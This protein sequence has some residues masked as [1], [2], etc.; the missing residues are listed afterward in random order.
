MQTLDLIGPAE[1][2]ASANELS[3]HEHFKTR[4]LSPNGLDVRSSCGVTLCVDGEWK[5]FE[6][7]CAIVPGGDGIYPVAE[8][9][10]L[11]RVLKQALQK[12]ELIMSVCTGAFLLGHAGFLE[13]QRAT[14]H[15][16]KQDDLAAQFSDADVQRNLLYVKDK[17]WT[18]AGVSTGM[19][20]ALSLVEQ[21]VNAKLAHDVAKFLVL[22]MR[23]AGFEDQISPP[24]KS[25]AL[26]TR[27]L[28]ETQSHIS[29]H[30]ELELDIETLAKRV[31][32]SPR[33][34]ARAFKKESGQTPGAFVREVRLERA[35]SLLVKSDLSIDDIAAR[36]GIKVRHSFTRMFKQ[37]FGLSPQQYRAQSQQDQGALKE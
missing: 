15:W 7:G 21:D 37:E 8:D 29:A 6:K 27:A 13:G 11:L 32:M 28:I 12:S 31:G 22:Y 19:D 18:S 23:R 26:E 33:N 9:D 30:P 25:Q 10:A 20:L 16:S 36:V 34:F 4:L 5:D 24:L 3:Q 14:T 1:V 17:V 2:F 35:R